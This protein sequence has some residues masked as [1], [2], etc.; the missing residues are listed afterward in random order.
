AHGCLPL[1]ALWRWDERPKLEDP[2][3]HDL[4]ASSWLWMHY[5]FGRHHERLTRFEK[6]L[7]DAKEPHQAWKE[8]FGD[9]KEQELEEGL[10]EYVPGNVYQASSFAAP[11]EP[12]PARVEALPS[13]D[14]P[15][16]WA[17]LWLY[18]PG[19]RPWEERLRRARPEVQRALSEDATSV[20]AVVLRAGMAR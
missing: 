3:L 7:Y 8:A 20:A 10:Q 1:E 18:A 17:W 6:A 12:P 11:P 14:V 16:A 2:G 15:A 5:L 9:L 19:E 13:A 4:Y